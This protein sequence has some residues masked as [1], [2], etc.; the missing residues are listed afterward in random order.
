MQ[1]TCPAITRFAA[2]RLDQEVITD[3]CDAAG[4]GYIAR[5]TISIRDVTDGPWRP[6]VDTAESERAVAQATEAKRRTG[7]DPQLWAP[8]AEFLR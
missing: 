6:P 4:R 5:T 3:P 8:G 2:V 7:R 1:P